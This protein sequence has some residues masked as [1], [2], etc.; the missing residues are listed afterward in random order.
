MAVGAEQGHADG[1]MASVF[2]MHS[3]RHLPVSGPVQVGVDSGY[4][5]VALGDMSVAAELIF[6]IFAPLFVDVRRP[7]L[8]G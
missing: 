1:Q 4:L 8:C 7:W 3:I 5:C 6:L 2:H